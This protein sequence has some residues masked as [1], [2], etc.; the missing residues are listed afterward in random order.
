MIICFKLPKSYI[1]SIF[2]NNFLNMDSNHIKVDKNPQTE[3]KNWKYLPIRYLHV[4]HYGTLAQFRPVLP[5][6]LT[7]FI[8]TEKRIN[9]ALMSQST[10]IWGGIPFSA[11][12]FEV[13]FLDVIALIPVSVIYQLKAYVVNFQNSQII[14]IWLPW[15]RY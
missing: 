9:K 3:K 10:L 11:V 14:L 15:Q 6:R 8:V 1:Y 7:Y 4:S 2:H 13:S 12:T 5:A